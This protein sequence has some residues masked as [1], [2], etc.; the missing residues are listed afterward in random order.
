MIM[1][2]SH[3]ETTLLDFDGIYSTQPELSERADEWI[4]LADIAGTYLFCAQEAFQEIRRRLSARSARGLTFIGN[5]NYHYV[6][7]AL[8]CE[9]DRPFSLA[10]FDHHS[11]ARLSDGRIGLL[12]CGSWVAEAAARLPLLRQVHII[13][14]HTDRFACPPHVSDKIRFWSEDTSA[15][16]LVSAFPTEHVYISVDKDV[17]DRRFAVTNWDHGTMSLRQLTATLGRIVRA[18][19]VLGVDVCGELPAS[20]ADAWRSAKQIKRNELTNL[21]ILES[22]LCA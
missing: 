13:G 18:K 20:P 6:T 7:Y 16:Q 1:A 22:V 10:L 5:G 17:L 11:D 12:S 4:E 8:L 2:L 9:I 14:A 19:N 15:E 3:H 21:A